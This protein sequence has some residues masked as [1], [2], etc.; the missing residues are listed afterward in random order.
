LAGA[1]FASEAACPQFGDQ[2]HILK[3]QLKKQ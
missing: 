3:V 1:F 2:G